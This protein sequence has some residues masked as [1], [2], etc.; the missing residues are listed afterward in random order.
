MDKITD[1]KFYIKK[2]EDGA[3]YVV[4]DIVPFIPDKFEN[5]IFNLKLC[6]TDA[7]FVRGLVIETSLAELYKICPRD[8][9]RGD[10]YDSLVNFLK[11]ELGIELIISKNRY[12]T[13]SDTPW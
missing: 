4:Y 12:G 10:A 1:M 8:R 11:N 9:E 7:Y 2:K 5:D 6:I 3:D 13:I